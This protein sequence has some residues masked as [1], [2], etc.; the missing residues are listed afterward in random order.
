MAPP[1]EDSQNKDSINVDGTEYVKNLSNDQK[2]RQTSA[3]FNSEKEDPEAQRETVL[4]RESKEGNG[5][6]QNPLDVSLANPA[7]SK[8]HDPNEGGAEASLRNTL[9]RSTSL[10]MN[11]E[12]RG[13][14]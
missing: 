6:V 4:K 7:A 10:A 8:H 13:V 9:S 2:M 5:T 3:A 14:S 1:R 11:K 12:L